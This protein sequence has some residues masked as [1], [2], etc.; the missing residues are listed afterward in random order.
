MVLTNIQIMTFL[1][2][3]TANERNA[4]IADLLTEGLAGLTHMTDEEVRDACV[5][6]AKRT[7]GVFPVILTPIQK[8]RIKALMLWVQD[9]HRVDLPLSFP[10]GTTQQE[11]RDAITGALERD[12]R[13][14]IQRKEGDAYLDS[15]FD[16]KLKSSVQW[17]KWIEELDTTLSQIIGVKG[18]PLSYVIREEEAAAPFDETIDYN[19]AA[20]L[21]T[22]LTGP[23]YIQDARTVHKIISKNVDQI[24]DAYT[25]IKSIARHRH[26]RRDILALR[27]RYSS[28]A[29]V[30]GI[31]N[32]AKSDLESLQYRNERNF[33]FEK[34]SSRLQKAYDDLESQG[35]T[36]N[37]GDIVDALWD[38]IKHSELQHYIAS[39]KVDYQRNPRGYRLILQDIAA[40]VN[41]MSSTSTSSFKRGVNVSATYTREG[42]CP[43]TGVYTPNGSIFTGDYPKS[44]WKSD[45]VKPFHKQIMEAR[46]AENGD[47]QTR[48]QKRRVNAIKRT[49]KKLKSLE[50][51]ISA[52]KLQLEEAVSA[53]KKVSFS[54]DKEKKDESDN[55][56]GNSFGGKNSK[57]T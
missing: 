43:D 11:F 15:S 24:A 55:D 12:R 8:Q 33:S 17:Q 6:Y 49:N 1:G 35:R 4:I 36:V 26:G 9:M 48:S 44:K 46:K 28:D 7:D 52:A 45:S 25:Y 16:I 21:S 3:A 41:K 56:A 5:S 47:H 51:K 30:Q 23:E 22:A 14:K 50:T 19:D 39:L 29:A 13:R 54:D 27:E 57:K 40:E 31:I 37:N 34:F 2:I 53:G 20:I 18:L 10:N 42:T 32:K 38:R